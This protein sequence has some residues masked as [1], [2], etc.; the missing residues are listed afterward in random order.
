MSIDDIIRSKV[1]ILDGIAMKYE[2]SAQAFCADNYAEEFFGFYELK[3]RDHRI[4]PSPL[5]FNEA[6]RE[7]CGGAW[8]PIAEKA[9]ELFGEPSGITVF[10]DPGAVIKELEDPEGLAL[11]FYVFDI[12]FCRYDG[13]VLCFISGSNN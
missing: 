13:F 7:L 9:A 6:L 2:V 11:F 4:V 8:Q 10:D 3:D 1:G 5:S 12:M